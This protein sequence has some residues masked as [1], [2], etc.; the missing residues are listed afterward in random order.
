MGKDIAEQIKAMRVRSATRIAIAALHYLHSYARKEGF[1]KKFDIEAGRLESLRP[2][3]VVLHN[4]LEKVRGSRTGEGI[5]SLIEELESAKR[6]IAARGRQLIR[7]NSVV[8]THCE[9]T[10]AEELLIR[11]KARISKVFATETRPIF[12][13]VAT[14]RRL[15]TAGL[16][17]FLITDAACGFFMPEVDAVVVGADALRRE[18]LVNK[19]G[20]LPLLATA[21]AFGKR[22]LVA[23]NTFKMDRRERF[24][25]EFRSPGEI[26]ARAPGKAKVLNPVFDLTPWRFVDKVITERGVF[27][28]R[29]LVAM[30]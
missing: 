14:A 4:A 30:L 11:A 3:A 17:T 25:I 23:S 2:T 8:M 15:S 27:T 22:V 10:E 21:K 1:G 16:R 12:Q 18:G 7:K 24:D 19:V 28:P 5:L 29:R 20:T 9:S 6:A 13:G 26:I